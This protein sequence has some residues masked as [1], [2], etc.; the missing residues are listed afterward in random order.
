MN[1]TEI[2][3]SNFNYIL[4][5]KLVIKIFIKE[6]VKLLKFFFHENN[7]PNA[8]NIKLWEEEK[9]SEE[10]RRLNIFDEILN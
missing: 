9:K 1:Y 4:E 3:R 5:N 2:I 8:L 7:L 6:I 10:K